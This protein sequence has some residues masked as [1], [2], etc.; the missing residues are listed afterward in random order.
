[1]D[2]FCFLN[3]FMYLIIIKTAVTDAITSAVGSE[4]HTPSSPM[5]RG[6]TISSGSRK[7][8]WRDNDRK[9]LIFALPML[10]KKFVITI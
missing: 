5:K 8:I 2:L 1:M 3:F 6:R 9:M 10:W 7:S 4:I